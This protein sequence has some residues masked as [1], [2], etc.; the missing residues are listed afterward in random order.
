M[1]LGVAN[2]PTFLTK[3]VDRM[4]FLSYG[5][6]KAR[7]KDMK[8]AFGIQLQCTKVSGLRDVCR[9]LMVPATIT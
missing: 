1:L 7:H 4:A 8:E 6:E 9:T 3:P 5:G 2:S